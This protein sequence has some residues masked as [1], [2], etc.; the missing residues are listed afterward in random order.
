ML[1]TL[2]RNFVKN[3]LVLKQADSAKIQIDT[4]QVAQ[5]RR[6]FVGAVTKAWSDLGVSPASLKETASSEGDRE[7]LAATRIDDYFTKMVAEQAPFVA[8]PTPIANALRK[9]YDYSFNETGFDRAVEEAAKI[10]NTA[11]SA[12]KTAPPP[13]VVPLTPAPGPASP[14][15][16]GQQP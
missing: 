14:T 13:T 6:N 4:A 7:R 15:P 12:T 3:E 16:G 11:D 1:T 5:L 10:R 9:K 8:V 2:I